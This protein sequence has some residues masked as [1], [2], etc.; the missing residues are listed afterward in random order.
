MVKNKL[1]PQIEK[2]ITQR[3]VAATKYKTMLILR[4]LLRTQ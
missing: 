3:S 4:T 2:E 1:I